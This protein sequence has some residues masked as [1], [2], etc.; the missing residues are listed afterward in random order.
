MPDRS[1]V[2]FQTKRDTRAYAVRGRSEFVSGTRLLI[3]RD[4]ASEP[5]TVQLRK[6]GRGTLL[7]G[8]TTDEVVKFWSGDRVPERS[9]QL[10]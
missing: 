6:S 8:Q 2:R 1:K 5:V 4:R 9:R 3:R 10:G 7:A